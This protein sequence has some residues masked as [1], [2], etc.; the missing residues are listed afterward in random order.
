MPP[1]KM[2]EVIDEKWMMVEGDYAKLLKL[3]GAENFGASGSE[4][5]HK[6]L[7]QRWRT[8]GIDF[9]SMPSSHT[10]SFMSSGSFIDSE[11]AREAAEDEDIWLKADCELIVYGQAG[12][13]AEVKI[14]GRPIQLNPDGSF[15]LRYSLRDGQVVIPITAQHHTKEEKKRTITISAQRRKEA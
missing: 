8:L 6:F 14:D 12:K 2:S 3:S 7:A 5:L 11:A 13:N 15:S 9:N 10:S 1:G 4:Q